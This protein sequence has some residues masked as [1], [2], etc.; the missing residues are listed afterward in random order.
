[1]KT[2][3]NLKTVVDGDNVTITGKIIERK[4]GHP[5]QQVTVGFMADTNP[6]WIRHAQISQEAMFVKHLAAGAAI[7]LEEWVTNVASVIEPLL[8]HP[9]TF[10]R[11]ST[12]LTVDF[13]SELEVTLQWQV[14]PVE[15]ADFQDIPGQTS[16]IL[17]RDS[18]KGGWVRCKGS[19]KAGWTTTPPVKL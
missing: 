19:S 15:G 1:M 2:L 9:P 3:T 5:V 4:F 12:P 8:N 11:S 10:R 17:D 18:V 6:N 7:P 14:A 16:R 13:S